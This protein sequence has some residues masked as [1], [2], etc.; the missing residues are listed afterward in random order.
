M[1]NMFK[2]I[3]KLCINAWM[4]HAVIYGKLVENKI[5]FTI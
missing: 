5:I 3:V 1:K 4:E 2:K